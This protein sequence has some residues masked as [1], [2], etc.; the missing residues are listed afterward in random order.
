M[1]AHFTASVQETT[2]NVPVLG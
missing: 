1:L 2:E